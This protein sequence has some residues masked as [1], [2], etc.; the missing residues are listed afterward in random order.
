MPIRTYEEAL[1][2]WFS[3]TNYEQIGM[4]QDLR[5]LKL[6]RMRHLLDRLGRPHERLRIVHIAGT[7]GKGSTAALVAAVLQAAGRRVGLFTSPHLVR[8][9][10]RVQVNGQ[11]ITPPE[12]LA[13]MQAVEAAVA[14]VDAG[15]DAPVT[16]FEVMTAVGLLHFDRQRVDWAVLETGLGGRFDATNVCTPAVSVITSI[17]FDHM[18]QLGHTL[19]AIAGEKAGIIKPGVPVVSGATAPD[20][21][22]VIRQRAEQLE[23]PLYELQRHFFLEFEEGSVLQDRPPRACFRRA[24]TPFTPWFDLGLW[25]RHQAEN[26][27]LAWRTLGMLSAHGVSIDNDT[28]A[29]GLRQVRWPA[30]LEIVGRRPWVILDCAHNDASFRALVI[31]L[32]SAISARRRLLI[33]AMSR[34]K[35][36][37]ALTPLLT[38]HFDEVWITRYASSSR[39]ADPEHLAKLWTAAGGGPVHLAPTALAAWH[40]ARAVAHADDLICV[41][42]SVFLAGELRETLCPQG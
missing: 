38:D 42:G 30:R 33:L 2:Y 16:F 14:D 21:A 22:A 41:T 6:D 34:D 11:V 25:G 32:S 27:A 24:D 40:E 10:E 7:K 23:A 19:A 26:G 3:R 17:S 36:L 28:L 13:A 5:T 18:D 1:R 4:P 35:D 29:A 20:A 9:E 37:P 31:W 39:G 8:V 12:L 15:A